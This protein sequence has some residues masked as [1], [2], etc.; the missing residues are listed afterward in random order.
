MFPVRNEHTFQCR[1]ALR[2]KPLRRFPCQPVPLL[3]AGN[4]L[5]RC[6]LKHRDDLAGHGWAHQRA[7]LHAWS[8]KLLPE[9]IFAS[10]R[11]S[12]ILT[13]DTAC[14]QP[15]GYQ[16]YSAEAVL[17]NSCRQHWAGTTR[18]AVHRTPIRQLG[19]LGSVTDV[20]HLIE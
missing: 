19:K 5:I 6:Y 7:M 14:T 11:G 4:L 16:K 3:R 8:G 20:P 15:L 1:S 13:N 12:A 18:V 17:T 2:T 10:A 9:R